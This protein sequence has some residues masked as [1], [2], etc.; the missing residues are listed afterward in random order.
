[1]I[2]QKLNVLIITIPTIESDRTI[3]IVSFPLKSALQQNDAKS[4]AK[5]D[6]KNDADVPVNVLVNVPVNI[7][8]NVPVNL[9][10][11]QRKILALITQNVNI[12]HS[13]MAKVLL[14][15]SPQTI[16]IRRR[17]KE[18]SKYPILKDSKYSLPNVQL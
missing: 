11:T 6:A 12:T 17:E 9:T 10:E 15:H 7:P 14:N 2:I 4:D 1:M 3:A 13:E 8:V 18:N 5:N 16:S